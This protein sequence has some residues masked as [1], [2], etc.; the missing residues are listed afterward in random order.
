MKGIMTMLGQN[1]IEKKKKEDVQKKKEKTSGE[2]RD[3]VNTGGRE[4]GSQ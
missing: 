3:E 4:G 1:E 2:G